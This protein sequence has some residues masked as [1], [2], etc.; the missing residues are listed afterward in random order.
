LGAP[1][2]FGHRLNNHYLGLQPVWGEAGAGTHHNP[3]A[4]LIS[5]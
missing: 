1:S 5:A 4:C 3:G 2:S